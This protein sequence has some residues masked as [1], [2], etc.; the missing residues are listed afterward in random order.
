MNPNGEQRL[1]SSLIAG[2][3]AGGA[4]AFFT[5]P[6]DV[7]KTRLQTQQEIDTNL[8][9]CP[10]KAAEMTA[11]SKPLQSQSVIRIGKC[12][13]DNSPSRS[14]TNSGSSSGGSGIAI[15]SSKLKE[16]SSKVFSG[17]HVRRSPGDSSPLT[18]RASTSAAE[19][20]HSR[21]N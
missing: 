17:S 6:L 7:I 18:S 13:L 16:G 14:G 20:F 19:S 1:S 11:T 4:A 10:K 21:F 12:E 9:Q 15:G 8:E 3:V 5:T 2:C